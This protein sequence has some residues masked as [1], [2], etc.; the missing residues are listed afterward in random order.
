MIRQR[1]QQRHSA[2]CATRQAVRI[3]GGQIGA[4][5]WIAG[6]DMGGCRVG[7]IVGVSIA[8]G[9]CTGGGN[10]DICK[11]Q[12]SKANSL[13]TIATCENIPPMRAQDW[14]RQAEQAG[15][16]V[17]SVSG[18]ALVLKC[19]AQGCAGHL[20]LPLDN[21]GPTPPACILPHAGQYSQKLMDDY[22]SLIAELVRRRRSIG[23]D[24]IDLNAAI[25]LA[26][27]HLSKLE[28]LHRIASPPTLILWAQSLGLALTTAPIPLPRATI[29]AIDR[30]KDRPYAASQVRHK[31][32]P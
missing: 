10:I 17:T 4:S 22:Q 25:G 29:A 15:W 20:S 28:A 6:V 32:A 2:C 23:L 3:I 27:G 16:R 1:D 19:A 26:D 31:I 13:Q 21:L 12:H 18:R 14:I 8:R 11:P 30:R 24:Q 9:K 5:A 7:R